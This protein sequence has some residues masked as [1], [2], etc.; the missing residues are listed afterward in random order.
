MQAS[1]DPRRFVSDELRAVIDRLAAWHY[2]DLV[3][4]L[5]NGDRY[6]HCADFAAY[7]DT[8]DRA[9]ERWTRTEEWMRMSI[10]NTARSGRFSAD[11]TVAEYAR[12]IW[13][14]EAMPIRL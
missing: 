12:E 5:T 4:L 13:G 10:L 14:V 1:Y 9:A 2:D 11:R 7:V 3:N 8:Q 6:F